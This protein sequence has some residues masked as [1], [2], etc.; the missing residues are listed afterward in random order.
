[1][2]LYIVW[3]KNGSGINEKCLLREDGN[4]VGVETGEL[5]SIKDGYYASKLYNAKIKSVDDINKTGMYHLYEGY[6]NNTEENNKSFKQ[7]FINCFI[8]VREAHYADDVKVYQCLELD[9]YFSE[10]E[11]DLVEILN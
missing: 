1:M 8:T 4:Y 7:K 9:E 2:Q 5:Y 11:I 10:D 6:S 3:T